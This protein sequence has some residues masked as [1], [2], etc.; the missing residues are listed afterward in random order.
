MDVIINVNGVL[1][2]C[3]VGDVLKKML[4]LL[5]KLILE[6]II[7]KV[8]YL[9]SSMV[10]EEKKYLLLQKKN[11]KRYLLDRKISK[12][13]IIKELQKKHFLNWIIRLE[14]KIMQMILELRHVLYFSLILT[15]IVQMREIVERFYH[16]DLINVYL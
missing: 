4:I 14:K 6:L 7:K 11:F 10:M 16:K 2:Q 9:V 1:A 8:N 13:A 5:Q 3:K 15:Y 12:M